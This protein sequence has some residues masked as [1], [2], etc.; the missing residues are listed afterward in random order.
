M[1]KFL[2]LAAIAALPTTLPT[3]A[4]AQAMTTQAISGTR[5]DVVA[6]GEVRRVPD[7][8]TINAGVVTT[9]PTATAAIAQNAEAMTKVRQALTRAGIAARDI[10]TSAINLYPDYRQ[11]ERGGVPQLIAY[12]A[13]N[14]LS[15]RFR[16]IKNAGKILDALVAQGVNQI[17]GPSL[18]LA[19]PKEALDEARANAVKAA[20]ARAELYARLTGK[21]VG[22]TL[23]ISESGAM[24]YPQPMMRLQAGDVAGTQVDPG[25]QALTVTLSVS[26]ELE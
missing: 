12:R 8:A 11:D 7:L 15:I 5:L 21:R 14:Q 26:F 25:E 13:S 16:D 18:S 22:R 4:I 2:L 6:T 20:R 24:P 3:T 9:A 17:D 23:S 19:D 1:K 10:Q